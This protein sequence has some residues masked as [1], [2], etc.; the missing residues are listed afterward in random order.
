MDD[1]QVLAPTRSKLRGAVRA[2]NE[3]LASLR[4]EKRPNK[5]FIGKSRGDSP[6]SGTVWAR[7]YSKLAEAT[8][9][10]FVDQAT[11]LMSKGEGARQSSLAWEVC[12]A[13]ARLGERWVGGFRWWSPGRPH[14]RSIAPQRFHEPIRIA[15]GLPDRGSG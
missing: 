6:S 3:V 2:V 10:R 8:I 4:L 9:K 11:R 13:M 5:T 7:A 12:A 15:S 14:T 1:I